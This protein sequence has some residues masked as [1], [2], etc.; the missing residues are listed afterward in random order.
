MGSS[1]VHKIS[2]I[3]VIGMNRNVSEYDWSSAG[4]RIDGVSA[5]DVGQWQRN[6]AGHPE[7]GPWD[8]NVID[9]K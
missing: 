7:D 5:I 3:Y 4:V 6:G 8:H 2:T 9:V 1:V